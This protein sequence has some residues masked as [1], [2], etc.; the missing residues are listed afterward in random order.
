MASLRNVD[1][2]HTAG[3]CLRSPERHPQMVKQLIYKSRSVTEIT[4]ELIDSV[5]FSA[6]RYNEQRNITGI[7][8]YSQ[9]IFL[10]LVEGAPI[11]IDDLF[12][13][14]LTDSRHTDIQTVY[15]GYSEERAY[16]NW[17]MRAYSSAES[18]IH[19]LN[20]DQREF[21]TSADPLVGEFGYESTWIGSFMRSV[22]RDHLPEIRPDRSKYN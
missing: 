3:V 1:P 19:V 8:L 17:S 21:I 18:P 6:A 12:T 7:L 11:D 10:Q 20:D 13:R 9:N 2:T 4:P 22:C 5:L 15:L 16:P 14:I